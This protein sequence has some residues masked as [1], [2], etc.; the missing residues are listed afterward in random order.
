M[1]WAAIPTKVE[2]SRVMIRNASMRRL[3]TAVA[4]LQAACVLFAAPRAEA[5]D[6]LSGPSVFDEE[7]KKDWSVE[8]V[9][10]LFLSG[11]NGEL[12]LPSGTG[13]IPVDASFGDLASNLDAAFAGLLDVRYRRWHLI[14]DNFWV[15]L[16]TD[17]TV[18]LPSGGLPA[19]G[20]VD[21]DVDADSAFGTLAVAYELPLKRAFA[22]DLY[23]GARWWYVKNGVA[24]T[25]QSPPPNGFAGELTES[26]WDG[27]VGLRWRLPITK[28]WRVAAYGDIGAG[29]AN[30]DWQAGAHVTWYPIHYVG[31]TAGYR[32]LGVDYDN[33]GFLYDVRMNGFLLGLNL[34]Y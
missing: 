22:L 4:S 31:L 6:W 27:I 23:T 18:E 34:R 15:R 28:K 12:A 33:D 11:L 14:S 26:W 17:Q 16:S 10:Y 29:A 25:P 3:L 8:L 19:D 30:L 21:A 2:G 20:L 32:V 1:L 7:G 5:W 9:P 24:F 13:T